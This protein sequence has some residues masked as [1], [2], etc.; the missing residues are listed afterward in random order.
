MSITWDSEVLE[1]SAIVEH[2]SGRPVSGS[3]RTGAAPSR[4]VSWE[5]RR[6]CRVGVGRGGLCVVGSGV[7][8]SPSHRELAGELPGPRPLVLS[9]E[10]H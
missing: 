9:T 5:V 3:L 8:R 4:A 7:G 10:E 2:S 1:A 6:P